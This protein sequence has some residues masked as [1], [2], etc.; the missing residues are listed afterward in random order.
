M[1]GEVWAVVGV[2]VALFVAILGQAY[3]LS[4]RID[5]LGK[6]LRSEIGGLRSELGGRIDA[7]TAEVSNLREK[8]AKLGGLFEGF[9]T[10]AKEDPKQ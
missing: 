7:L 1:I 3:Y 6:D 2:G 4:D 9:R 8:V 5:G 10:W